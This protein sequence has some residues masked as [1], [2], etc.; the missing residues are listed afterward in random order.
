[1]KKTAHIIREVAAGIAHT[2]SA[3]LNTVA[4]KGDM[5]TST[6][7]AAHMKQSHPAWRNRRRFINALFFWQDDHCKAAWEAD[8]LRAVAKFQANTPAIQR[9]GDVVMSDKREDL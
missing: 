9:A 2:A 3:M 4:F 7:A 8:F 5:H 1:V 6:S